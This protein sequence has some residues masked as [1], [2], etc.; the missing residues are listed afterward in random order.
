V[1]VDH[2]SKHIETVGLF[3]LFIPVRNYYGYGDVLV[4]VYTSPT[5]EETSTKVAKKLYE[6]QWFMCA[7]VSA[8]TKIHIEVKPCLIR[9]TKRKML[10]HCT[11]LTDSNRGYSSGGMQTK[12]NAFRGKI[13][14]WLRANTSHIVVA[15]NKV[16]DLAGGKWSV[17]PCAFKDKEGYRYVKVRFDQ[18]SIPWYLNS[19]KTQWDRERTK[20]KIKEHSG[21]AITEEILSILDVRTTEILKRA[22]T[23][24]LNVSMI[25]QYAAHNIQYATLVEEGIYRA[26]DITSKELAKPDVNPILVFKYRSSWVGN[27]RV[28]NTFAII[29]GELYRIEK[30]YG[31][32][33]GLRDP[34]KIPFSWENYG[35]NYGGFNAG[36][37]FKRSECTIVSKEDEY[38]REKVLRAAKAKM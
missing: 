2:F 34:D 24:P 32:R 17:G 21:N 4:R 9:G 5:D 31:P 1:N 20:Q 14:D 29:D 15:Q 23:R 3:E 28:Q 13:I 22:K 33:Y 8:R 36:S 30:S 18:V 7:P 25:P 10:D 6:L 27:N 35:S 26:T 38:I 12:Q 19:G 11:V 37:V 16:L